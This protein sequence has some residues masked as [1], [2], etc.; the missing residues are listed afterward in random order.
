MKL[1][2]SIIEAW[3]STERS[4][5]LVSA[6]VFVGSALALITVT[7]AAHSTFVP[8]QGG[9]YREG[10]VGQPS[11]VNP[12]TSGNPADQDLSALLF[13]PMKTLLAAAEQSKDATTYTLKLW[14]NLVWEDGEPLTSDDLIFTIGVAQEATAESSFAAA[15]RGVSVERVSMLQIKLTFPTP[16]IFF[17]DFLLRLPVIPEH[18]WGRIPI[19]N[20]HLSE[21]ALQPVGNGPYRV[22]SFSKAKDGF[23]GEYHLVPNERYLGEAPFITDLYIK[24]FESSEKLLD[25]FRLKR[26][27]GFGFLPPFPEAH[28]VFEGAG[29]ARVSLPRYYAVF[30]NAT[31]NDLLADSNFRLALSRA[32]NRGR[33]ADEVFQGDA[34]SYF[35]GITAEDARNIFSTESATSAL[36]RAKIDADASLTLTVP[37]V[38]FLVKVAEMVVADWSAV[39]IPSVTIKKVPLVRFR[40]EVLAPRAYEM[41]L[42]P[43]ALTNPQDLY[44]FWHSVSRG[45]TGENFSLYANRTTDSLLERIRSEGDAEARAN[46]AEQVETNLAKDLPAVF[47]VSL[48]Y[49][50]VHTK[51]LE[52]FPHD[53]LVAP[54]D[55]FLNVAEWS[56]ARVRVIE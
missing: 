27:N 26:I 28:E 8:V 32:V 31:A 33:I 41:V 12:I 15:L 3:G 34:E 50:H 37:D 46:L 5:A 1:V 18:I 54:S 14:E 17:N 49:T 39:G 11:I 55:R 7:V 30:L 38:P 44:P 56:V 13:A 16:N 29:I 52:G 6:L 42:A 53:T 43:H 24:F 48:P 21:Y 22:A 19:K 10:I 2:R 45:A 35:P 20:F 47:L 51:D 4:T 25:A 36:A 9:T 40:D 23:V